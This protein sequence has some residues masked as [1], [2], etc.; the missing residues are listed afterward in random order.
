MTQVYGG[1]ENQDETFASQTE[2]YVGL[3]DAKQTITFDGKFMAYVTKG[4][5]IINGEKVSDGDLVRGDDI[6]FQAQNDSQIIIV[7]KI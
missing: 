1:N 2:V 5:G 4:N 7:R 3:I 6:S